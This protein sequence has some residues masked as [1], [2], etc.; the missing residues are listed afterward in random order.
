MYIT[1]SDKQSIATIFNH[2]CRTRFTI[3]THHRQTVRHCFD[4]C[5]GK[6]FETG[7]HYENICSVVPVSGIADITWQVDT[8]AK[9]QCIDTLLQR[10]ARRAFT[11]YDQMPQRLRRLKR[12]RRLEGRE[13]IEQQVET[14]LRLQPADCENRVL[15]TH[16]LRGWQ[17]RRFARW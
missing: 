12:L 8:S 16:H 13:S 11:Q 9:P 2:F 7:T 10:T 5:I 14:F 17:A 3:K 4:Q 6:S 1:V 15:L